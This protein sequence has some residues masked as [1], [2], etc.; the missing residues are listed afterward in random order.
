ML[1]QVPVTLEGEGNLGTEKVRGKRWEVGKDA[2]SIPR[3]P[4]QPRFRI[5]DWSPEI[6][7]IMVAFLL[8][9]PFSD[10]ANPDC[11][12]L[13]GSWNKNLKRDR[14]TDRKGPVYCVP[15]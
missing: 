8:A 9:N 15:S 11:L 13:R 7:G 1:G 4:F 2:I 6:P 14:A 10:L 5:A 12:N 3:L